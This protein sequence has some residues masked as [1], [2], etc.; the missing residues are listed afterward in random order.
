MPYCGKCGA[1]ISN[2]VGYCTACGYLKPPESRKN[3]AKQ[4]PQ[5][6]PLTYEAMKEQGLRPLFNL[7]CCL[8]EGEVHMLYRGIVQDYELVDV[9]ESG[10][11]VTVRLKRKG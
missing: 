3:P 11:V 4:K 1:Y 6:P 9:K 2:T 5:A 10:D 8:I 7:E